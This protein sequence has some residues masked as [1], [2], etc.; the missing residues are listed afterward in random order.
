MGPLKLTPL[1]YSQIAATGAAATLG[2][3]P[4][5]AN[6]AVISVETAAI[7]WRDDGTPPTASIGMPIAAAAAPLDYYG[8]LGAFEIIAQTG[9]PVVNVNFYRISG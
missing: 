1:G 4:A 3:I 8:N 6:M 7:R 9:S 2:T 5:G